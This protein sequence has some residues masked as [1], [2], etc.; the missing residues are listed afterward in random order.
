MK[1]AKRFYKTVTTGAVES[2]FGVFLDGRTLKT[3]QKH[4]LK[5][6]RLAVAKLIAAEWD[7]QVETIKP[8]TMPVTRLVNV[9]IELA[10]DNRDKLIAEACN[11]AGTDLLCYRAESPL[12]LK[13]RQAELWDPV[14]RWAAT[15]GISLETSETLTAIDQNKSSLEKVAEFARAMDDLHLT[16]LVH[17]TAVYG[18]A[19]LALAVMKNH[20]DGSQAFDLSRLD[21]LYQIEQWGQDDEAAE[22]AE[23]LAAEITAL[24]RIIEE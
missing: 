4:L 12:D 6:D 11:Y 13:E 1:T 19:I 16:L 23:N 15:Y 9:S 21:N 10:P 2:G 5:V 20:I 7:A 22:I 24:C 14:L 17:L 3:P 8:E 18:S